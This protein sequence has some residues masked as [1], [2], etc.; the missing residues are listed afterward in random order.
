MFQIFSWISYDLLCWMF[1]MPVEPTIHCQIDTNG[2]LT[3]KD[4][5]RYIMREREIYIYTWANALVPPTPFQGWRKES[6]YGQDISR[7]W[8]H[9]EDVQPSGL[10]GSPRSLMP[11]GDLGSLGTNILREQ[12]SQS[13]MEPP[14]WVDPILNRGLI[15]EAFHMRGMRSESL[16]QAEGTSICGK[17]PTWVLELWST[18]LGSHTL[19]LHTTAVK[20]PKAD[21]RFSVKHI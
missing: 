16:V 13:H 3:S 14:Q 12:Y 7:L 5:D 1:Q 11:V 19:V 18:P 20:R 17:P 9:L 2:K 6:A 15:W 4:S 8:I 10:S 21:S